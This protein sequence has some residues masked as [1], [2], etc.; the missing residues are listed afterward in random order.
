M[1]GFTRHI[2]VCTNQRS[3][4]DPRGSCSKLG[5]EALHAHFKQEAKRLNLK[6]VVR[7]NKAGCLDHCALGP[8]V[9]IYPEGV[10]YRVRTEADA[11]EI[12]ERHVLHGE[13]VTRLL[14]PDHPAPS[15][16]PPLK[17]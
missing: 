4:D 3:A 8:S 7:A 17:P 11:T 13:V 5:S 16:L 12:M 1:S 15:A 6:G 2:F 9:V 10:W 14:M